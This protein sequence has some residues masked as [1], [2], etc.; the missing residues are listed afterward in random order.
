M[1]TVSDQAENVEPLLAKELYDALRKT[2]Q[3]GTGDTLE[4]TQQLA[5]LGN[6]PEAQKFEEKARKEIEDLKGGVE[7][8]AESV[9]GDEGEALRQARAELD[10]VRKE[11]EHEIAQARPDLAE[12]AAP[13]GGQKASTQNASSKD[14][15][16]TG[17]KGEKPAGETAQAGEP[18]ADKAGDQPGTEPGNQSGGKAGKDGQGKGQRPGEE[19]SAAGEG[20]G[21]TASDAQ[22]QGKKDGQGKGEGQAGQ[23]AQASEGKGKAAGQGKGEGAGK[24][25]AEN[26]GDAPNAAGGSTANGGGQRAAGQLRELAGEGREAREIGG[27]RNAGANGGGGAAGGGGFDGGYGGGPLTGERFVEWSDRL[28]NVE[29]MVDD[30]ALRTEV[31]RIREIAKGMRVEFKQHQ[32]LPKWDMVKTKISAPLAELRDRLTE[33][34]ARRESK[35]SLVPIDRDPVPAQYA[36]RVRRYYEE[37]GRSR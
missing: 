20:K 8:A 22:G 32:T 34:L 12:N 25:A 30:P 21:Q 18:K 28:R 14:G 35:E 3:A 15:K 6:S 19:K 7:R 1:Q 36:E 27:D 24:G 5:Q 4:K 26:S 2:T 17:E 10:K 11:L 31:A 9:L 29:E 37:L 13:Q 33:E 23:T 16:Q